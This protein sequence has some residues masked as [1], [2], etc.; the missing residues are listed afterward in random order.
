M[1]FF[2]CE[3]DKEIDTQKPEIDTTI[4]N[5]FPANC[6]DTIYFGE[7]FTLNLKFTDNVE[8]GSFSLDIHHNFDH[9]SHSTEFVECYLNPKKIPVNPYVLIETHDIPTGQSEY[10]TN[11][12]ITIP[13]SNDEGQL[14]DK[15]DYHFDIRITDKEGWSTHFGMGIKM[16][17][18]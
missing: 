1:I 11:L 2:S 18:R 14:F 4:P 15:G 5:A 3:D 17:H 16:M 7:P 10:V 13:T 8:L 12:P 6:T 9:H